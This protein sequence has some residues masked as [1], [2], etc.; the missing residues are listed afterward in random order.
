VRTGTGNVDGLWITA[1]AFPRQRQ[2]AD[3]LSVKLSPATGTN[4][5]SQPFDRSVSFSTPYVVS[6]RTTLLAIGVAKG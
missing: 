3:P 1:R 2:V 6:F 4:A 5:Q